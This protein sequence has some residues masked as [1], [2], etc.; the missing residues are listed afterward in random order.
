MIKKEFYFGVLGLIGFKSLL[1]F[2]TGDTSYLAYVGFFCFFS[3]FFI[4]KIN[5]SK[6]DERYIENKK[7]ASVFIGPLGIIAMAIIWSST[8]LIK[9]IELIRALIF[10]LSAILLNIYAIKLYI[11]EEK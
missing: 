2:Y 9:D 7:I 6:E 10:L 1:Y 5:A 11:L 8:V 3:W 4:G